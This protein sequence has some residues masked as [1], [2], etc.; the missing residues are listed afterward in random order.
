MNPT[1]IWGRRIGQLKSTFAIATAPI[2]HFRGWHERSLIWTAARPYLY[3]RTTAD[4]RAIIGGEDIDFQ[5]PQIR[6]ALLPEKTATLEAKL[7]AMFP[8][9]EFTL[10]CA[11]AGTF[12]ETED[13]M[14]YIGQSG[15]NP[16]QLFC[17]RLRREWYHLQHDRRGDYP[18][19]MPRSGKSGGAAVSVWP[20]KGRVRFAPKA[21]GRDGCP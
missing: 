16:Q 3:L 20:V 14:A 5:D 19:C 13:S 21:Q 10:E 18:R 9:M 15:G 4:D 8:D 12:E 2:R 1:S 7:R 11:W 17:A 6:D